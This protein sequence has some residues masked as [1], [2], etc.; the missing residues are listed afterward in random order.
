MRQEQSRG[1]EP[2]SPADSRT[3]GG[4]TASRAARSVPDDGLLAVLSRADLSKEVELLVLR[5][6]NAK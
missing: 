5:H 3:K 6:E 2:I 4:S 1:S